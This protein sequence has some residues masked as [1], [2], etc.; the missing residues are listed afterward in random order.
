MSSHPT[1]FQGDVVAA[2]RESI[3][4]AIPES[5]TL[6]SPNPVTGLD[7][8]EAKK[9]F[10]S[11]DGDDSIPGVS[12]DDEKDVTKFTEYAQKTCADQFGG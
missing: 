10:G 8:D 11:K 12:K 7:Y 9:S 1:N 5:S 4:R 3:E 2:I 6:V